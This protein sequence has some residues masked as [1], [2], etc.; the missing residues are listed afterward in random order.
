MK[1]KKQKTQPKDVK[2]IVVVDEVVMQCA[3]LK[4]CYAEGYFEMI[5]KCKLCG[6]CI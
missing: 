1:D 2:E 3:G 6:K 5:E 4:L